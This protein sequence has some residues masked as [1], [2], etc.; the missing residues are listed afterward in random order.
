M[1]IPCDSSSLI[2]LA[3]NCLLRIM[4]GGEHRFVIPKR[5]R[6]E[7]FDAPFSTKRFKLRAIQMDSFL[8][9]GV[10]EVIDDPFI[11]DYAE[12]VAGL[13]N[14]LLT[15][16][17]DNVRIIHQ[18]EAEVI[19][20][21]KF[22]KSNT[23]LIDERTTR[24]LIEDPDQLKK[25]M[26][27][28]T[29]LDVEIN[30]KAKRELMKEFRGVNVM[31]SAEVFAYAYEKRLFPQYDVKEALEGGLYA[32]KFSGCSMTDEEIKDYIELLG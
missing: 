6:M 4:E 20:C 32:L 9:R 3:D 19:A 26:K 16:H 11:Y 13:A 18:G 27:S 5:I 14:S 8:K 24:H 7:I 2:S 1:K 22:L 28:R 31:R 17:G 12:R 29:G 15:Y 30:E 25:Y 21:M 23:I 10:I